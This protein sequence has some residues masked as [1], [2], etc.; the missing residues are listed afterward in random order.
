MAKT[1]RVD[2]ETLRRVAQ[3]LLGARFS[4]AWLEKFALQM[5]GILEETSKLD[6]LDLTGMEPATVFGNGGWGHA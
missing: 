6:E 3:Q 4:E 1:S 5:E 2:V